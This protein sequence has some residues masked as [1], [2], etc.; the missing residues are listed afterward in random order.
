MPFLILVSFIWAVS[1]GLIK[2]KL[3]GLDS[4][5]L[6]VVRIA[7]ATLVFL[8]FF[9]PAR[10][11]P[12]RL[13]AL[14][15]IGAVEFGC[16]YVLYM[17]AFGYLK[18]Y[19]V[20]LFTIFTPLWLALLDA[21]AQRR[22]PANLLAAVL[23]AVA[24]TAMACWQ[25]LTTGH[26]MLAGF[27]LVQASNLC[28]ALGQF[29]YRYVRAALPAAVSNASLFACLYIGALIVTLLVSAFATHWSQFR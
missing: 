27:V 16:M 11:A 23:L 18:A 28:F 9:R 1:F 12:S 24:G 10:I 19:E 22:L 7:F 29:F 20:A 13:F 25:S 8:P 6:G 2:G 26:D 4:S 3:A 15:A 17:A 5:A 14:A 21:I